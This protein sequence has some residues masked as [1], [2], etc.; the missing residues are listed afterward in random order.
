MN[1][2]ALIGTS[3]VM[4]EPSGTPVPIEG[5]QGDFKG[6]LKALVSGGQEQAPLTQ[7]ATTAPNWLGILLKLFDNDLQLT[8][9][10]DPTGE[11]LETT[12]T[13]TAVSLTELMTVLQPLVGQ[14]E[15]ETNAETLAL[16]VAPPAET[17]ETPANDAEMAALMQLSQLI[18]PPLPVGKPVANTPQIGNSQ[19][20]PQ[21]A[22]ATMASLQPELPSLAPVESKPAQTTNGAAP[23]AFTQPKA[24]TQPNPQPQPAA[25][26]PPATTTQPAGRP[27]SFET[28]PTFTTAPAPATESTPAPQPQ[29]Q[30]APPA[31]AAAPQPRPEFVA[32]HQAAPVAANAQPDQPQ[33]SADQPSIP[34]PTVANSATPAI[35]NIDL[36]K[37]PVV[38]GPQAPELP[39]LQQIV[40]SVKLIQ[41][42][43]ETEV[44]L[45]LRPESLGQVTV[46]LHMSGGDVSVRMM[47]DTPHAQALLQDNLP[48]L[49]AAFTAQGLQVQSLNID[50]GQNASTFGSPGREAGHGQFNGHGYQPAKQ[51][52]IEDQPSSTRSRPSLLSSLYSIDFQA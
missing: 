3:G 40:E 42:N 34:T 14:S 41:Q 16:A 36:G 18:A 15:A 25:P 28:A 19:P 10:P 30:P 46:Q 8:E 49:K 35:Q 32:M 13:E 24:D 12:Q 23:V 4:P 45:Q 52:L 44:R 11:A 6:I 26:Q 27:F 50:L 2:A 20:A 22:A 33:A 17:A 51:Y 29:P 7:A 5:S 43:G 47:A 31:S 39:A 37:T 48:Q 1:I 9:T 38:N 21:T